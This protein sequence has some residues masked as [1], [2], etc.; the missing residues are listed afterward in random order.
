LVAK[1]RDS[2]G[3]SQKDFLPAYFATAHTINPEKRV[4][5]QATCQK[6]VDQAISSTINLPR[7]TSVETVERIYRLAWEQGLKGVTV[8]REGSRE[9]ILITEKEVKNSQVEILPTSVTPRPV[10]LGGMT[11]QRTVRGVRETG[12]GRL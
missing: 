9:G 7:D 3:D 6:H 1:Y 12:Q 4:L 11:S 5:M 8:Y 10:T 2:N